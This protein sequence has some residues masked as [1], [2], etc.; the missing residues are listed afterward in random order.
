MRRRFWRRKPK[1]GRSSR[2]KPRHVLKSVPAK[3]SFLFRS[4]SKC[5]AAT[6]SHVR[7]SNLR[8]IPRKTMLFRWSRKVRPCRGR[9]SFRFF[10]QKRPSSFLREKSS[11][12]LARK[13]IPSCTSAFRVRGRS[14][15]KIRKSKTGGEGGIRT[16]DTPFGVH[17]LSR[18]A[19]SATLAPLRRWK[20]MQLDT[21]R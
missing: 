10:R 8:K 3:A 1:S 2:R 17:T 19:R 7:P 12:R 6:L 14:S 11:D 18:R 20:A 9:R 13:P 16:P 5:L 4:G 15:P 21:Q